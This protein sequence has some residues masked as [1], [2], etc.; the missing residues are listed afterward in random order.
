MAELTE[1]QFA[2]ITMFMR[3][4]NLA[5]K[6]PDAIKSQPEFAEAMAPLQEG[7][8]AIWELLDDAQR[9][10]LLEQYESELELLQIRKQ[11]QAI[12]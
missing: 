1:Q 10:R 4:A 2:Q 3:V 11:S 9:D 6:Y 5:S 7:V 8:A 12:D